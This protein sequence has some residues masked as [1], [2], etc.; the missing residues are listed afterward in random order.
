MLAMLHRSLS[1]SPHHEIRNVTAQP[2]PRVS[3]Q[4]R[5]FKLLMVQGIIVPTQYG[6]IS[7]NR[8]LHLD[9]KCQDLLIGETKDDVNAIAIKLK[10][11]QRIIQRK[12]HL[13]VCIPHDRFTFV[14]QN[15]KTL[16]Y[17]AQ[18]LKLLIADT[19]AEI[20]TRSRKNSL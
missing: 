18:M 2:D 11:I 1:W 10:E 3:C 20:T 13:I 15:R 5:K 9:M 16:N 8:V 12:K 17:L 4:L 19:A 7:G 6:S 14:I